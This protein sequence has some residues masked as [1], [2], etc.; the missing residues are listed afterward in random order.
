MAD[1]SPVFTEPVG[2][3]QSSI[4]DIDAIKD[5]QVIEG[6][7]ED[8][9][10]TRIVGAVSDQIERVLA[11]P[12]RKRKYKAFFSRPPEAGDV[13]VLKRTPVISVDALKYLASGTETSVDSAAYR[14]I[15]LWNDPSPPPAGPSLVAPTGDDGWPEID[16]DDVLDPFWVEYTAGWEEVPFAIVQGALQYAVDRFKFTG[17]LVDVEQ[18]RTG[19]F[20]QDMISQYRPAQTVRF[21][22]RE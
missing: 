18:Y 10:L 11:R 1:I 21:F 4:L 16:A 14:A 2:D 3:Y 22:H 5:D 6:S 19:T 7:E 9:R 13:L 17:N 12:V 15:R 20:V 8:V